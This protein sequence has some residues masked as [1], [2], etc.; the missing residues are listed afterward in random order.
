MGK[1]KTR[2]EAAKELGVSI[3]TISNWIKRG[4]LQGQMI[5]GCQ[6][7]ET[8]SILFQ[9]SRLQDL[10]IIQKEIDEVI[11]Q[12][13]QQL[14]ALK[15]S[16]DELRRLLRISRMTHGHSINQ[17]LMLM[18]LSLSKDYLNSREYDILTDFVKGENIEQQSRKYNLSVARL[19]HIAHHGCRRMSNLTSL[20][21]TIQNHDVLNREVVTLK[22]LCLLQKRKIRELDETLA[23]QKASEKSLLTS[24][25]LRICKLLETP[26]ENTELSYRCI[27]ALRCLDVVTV[28]DILQYKISDLMKFR[29]FGNR[30]LADL[31][32]YLMTNGLKLGMDVHLLKDKYMRYLSDVHAESLK[33]RKSSSGLNAE[34]NETEHLKQGGTP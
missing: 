10:V 22:K 23:A 13:K 29:N 28:E 26:I 18:V 21:Q 32:S 25:E 34:D 30:S 16:E 7:V 33:K 9:Q 14:E 6:Y 3:Q 20:L 8:E 24:D 27:Y 17:E 12:N 4:F 5:G 19:Y 2:S 31:Q 1:F 11:G 15:D